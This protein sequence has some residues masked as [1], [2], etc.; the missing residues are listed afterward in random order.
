MAIRN[1]L[2]IGDPRLKKE[3]KPIIDFKSGVLKG[4]AQDMAETMLAQGLIGLAAPQ[5]GENYRAFVTQPRKTSARAMEKADELRFYINPVI[6]FFS[7]E[8]NIIWEGCGCVPG[9]FGPVK[10]PASVTVRARDLDGRLFRLSCDGILA[11][12][13]QHEYDHLS[14]IEFI[15]K[16]ED[17]SRLM[18][19][20]HYRTRIRNSARQKKAST[21]TFVKFKRIPR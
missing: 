17:Y 5:I 4:L 16:I 3:N 7:E 1:I 2:T 18:T 13:I 9:I 20:E 14:G 12:V 10:R 19:Q 8:H 21:I 6:T 15:E 11:R